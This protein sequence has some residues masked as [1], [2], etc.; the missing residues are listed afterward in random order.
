MLGVLAL[1]LTSTAAPSIEA[2]VEPNRGPAREFVVRVKVANRE[3][4][5][6][7]VS[8]VA[9]VL[10]N[11]ASF[12]REEL[13]EHDTLLR[14]ILWPNEQHE[15]KIEI[16]FGRAVGAHASISV[17]ADVVQGTAGTVEGT[18][19]DRIC[20]V[21]AE[22]AIGER[23]FLDQLD[24]KSVFRKRYEGI[25]IALME[26]G[27]KLDFVEERC[28]EHIS[29]SHSASAAADR[30]ARDALRLLGVGRDMPTL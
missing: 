29:R 4:R 3:A 21:D 22:H 12:T 30:V 28:L 13:L 15:R 18:G 24:C 5:T 8:I 19:K 10:V 11:G 6:C 25:D 14:R 17:T 16:V 20:R 7:Y 27:A 2:S 1:L 26:Q 9:D 23:A